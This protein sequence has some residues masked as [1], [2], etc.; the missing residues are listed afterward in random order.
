[1][2]FFILLLRTKRKK[3]EMQKEDAWMQSLPSEEWDVDEDD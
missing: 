1:V 3:Q 2:V